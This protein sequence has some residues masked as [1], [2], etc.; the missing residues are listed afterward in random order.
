M[1]NAIRTWKNKRVLDIGCSGGMLQRLLTPYCREIYGL[2]INLDT[3]NKTDIEGGYVCGDA[4]QLPLRRNYFD[5][6][7]CSHLLEHLPSIRQC[8]KEINRVMK[9]KGKFIV[10]YPIELFRGATC[11]PDVLLHGQKINRIRKIHLHK[12]SLK[13]LKKWI[14]DTELRIMRHQ[15]VFALQPMYLAVM[16]KMG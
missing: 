13:K 14:R 9:P 15:L 10:L 5:V 2:D 6:V 3:L 11:I 16:T 7:I 1:E 4:M 12:L 8:I